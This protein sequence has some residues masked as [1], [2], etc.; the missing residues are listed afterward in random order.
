MSVGM[1][2][3]GYEWVGVGGC[4]TAII[5]TIAE[6]WLECGYRRILA[7]VRDHNP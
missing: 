6:Y 7:P 1:G 2:W 5:I 3:C 4:D